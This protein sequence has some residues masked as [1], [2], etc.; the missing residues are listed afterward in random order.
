M[1]TAVNH[2]SSARIVPLLFLLAFLG[3]TIFATVIAA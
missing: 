2:K 3:I 1:E